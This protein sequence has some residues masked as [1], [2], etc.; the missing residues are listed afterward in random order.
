MRA[1]RSRARPPIVKSPRPLLLLGIGLALGLVAGVWIQHRW[2]LGRVRD[3][4]SVNH[5]R[6]PLAPADLA[7]LPPERRMVLVCVGQ[8]NA[9]NYGEPRAAAGAN[10]YAFADDQIFTAI[11][12]L[13]G[14]DGYG[15]SVWTRLGAKLALSTKADAIVFAVVAEGSTRVADW[16]PGGRCH[17]RLVRTLHQLRSAGLPADFVLWQQGEQEGRGAAVSG[18]D[19]ARDLAAV[20]HTT[21]QFFP[22]ATFLVA[23]STFGAGT[24]LNEQVRLAQA[25]AGRQPGAGVGPDVDRLGEAYRRDGI[26]FNARGLSAAADLWFDALQVPLARRAAPTPSP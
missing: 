4:L 14:G 25:A 3:E 20:H 23:Q 5:Q 11:D 18:H 24:A 10:V 6:A 22:D 17:E 8:S 15:G 13:P 2:P 26:H 21:R 19:Y 9:A 7:R 16:A 12:P 1:V